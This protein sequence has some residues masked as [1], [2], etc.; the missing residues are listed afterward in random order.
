M[1]V[2]IIKKGEIGALIKLYDHLHDNDNPVSS[3]ESMLRVWS[4]IQDNNQFAIFG[5]FK[6]DKLITSCAISI[7][8]NLTRDCRPYG[9]IE[10]VV[11]HESYR[12][13]GYGKIILT[14]TLE[15][16]WERNC[17]KAML[18]TGRLNEATFKFYES[19]GFN[20][21][22]KQAFIAKPSN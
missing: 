3:E 8:P 13:N 11:T 6:N 9:V 17:Y 19:V 20:R 21:D 5:G 22:E 1:E 7:I 10:N 14:S 12:K 16:A 18:M 2:R 15:Y 4:E